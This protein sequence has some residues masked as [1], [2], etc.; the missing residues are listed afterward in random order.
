MR[1]TL[2]VIGVAIVAGLIFTGYDG[3]MVGELRWENLNLFVYSMAMGAILFLLP[4][5]VIVVFG[6]LIRLFS[7]KKWS[8]RRNHYVALGASSFLAAIFL[9]GGHYGASHAS[10]VI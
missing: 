1:S 6:L 4:Y 10:Q 8:N 5:F 2:E 3:A 7:S 9:Y